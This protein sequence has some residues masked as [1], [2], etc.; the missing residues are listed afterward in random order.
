MT[1]ISVFR[2]LLLSTLWTIIP[3]ATAVDGKEARPADPKQLVAESWQ[4]LGNFLDDK[5]HEQFRENLS[6]AKAILIVPQLVRAGFILGGS[7]GRGVL[8]TQDAKSKSWSQPA[9]VSV[10]SASI[11]WQAGAEVAEMIFLIMTKRG[12]EEILDSKI[13]FGAR[14][15]IAAGGAGKGIGATAQTD[16]ISFVRGKGLYGG[17][18]GE[19]MVVTPDDESV[20]RYYGNAA[21]AEDI[22][23]KKKV[24]SRD[25]S[26]LL[27]LLTK[28]ARTAPGK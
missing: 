1:S 15:S 9:F 22:L 10:G 4:T 11:G 7:G 28:A 26:K 20:K 17:L 23:V 14:T 27:S 2:A 24:Y 6:Q 16:V 3:I 18:A 8:L 5:Q 21:A 25:A 12:F 19:G 13:K